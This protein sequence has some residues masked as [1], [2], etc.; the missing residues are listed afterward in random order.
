MKMKSSPLGKNNRIISKFFIMA[1][2]F[3]SSTTEKWFHK[4]VTWMLTLVSI[5]AQ[6]KVKSKQM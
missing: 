2:S 1:N 6:G 5:P 3:L 4:T